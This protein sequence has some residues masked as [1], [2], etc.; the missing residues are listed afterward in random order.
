MYKPFCCLFFVLLF[1]FCSCSKSNEVTLQSAG[2]DVNAGNCDTANMKF[3]AHIVPILQANCTSCH[4]AA[5]APAGVSTQ[6]YGAVKLIADNGR[7]IGSIT[8]SAGYTAM[9]LGAPKLAACDINKIKAWMARGAQN[10]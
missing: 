1:L 4:N 2:Q 6:T 5:V 7:L 9:P 3:S 10:N 8:H